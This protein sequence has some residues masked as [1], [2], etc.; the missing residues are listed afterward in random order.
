M[1]ERMASI[2]SVQSGQG[3]SNCRMSSKGGP[4]NEGIFLQSKV[5]HL[6]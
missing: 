1:W 3:A 2:E 5:C 6:L 4:W